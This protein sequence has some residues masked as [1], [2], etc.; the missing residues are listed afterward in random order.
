[1]VKIILDTDIS[2]DYDDVGAMAVLHALAKRGEAEILATDIDG[3]V[4]LVTSGNGWNVD[5][6]FGGPE[7]ETDAPT[8]LEIGW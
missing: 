7:G 5:T 2:P 3:S 1:M 8:S 6:Q 4:T